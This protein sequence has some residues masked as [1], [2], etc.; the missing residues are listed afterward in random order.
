MQQA[1]P[2]IIE[3]QQ[4]AK[5]RLFMKE[6]ENER[7]NEDR[8]APPNKDKLGTGLKAIACLAFLVLCLVL[9]LMSGRKWFVFLLLLL[10]C[11]ACEEWLLGKYSLNTLAGVPLSLVSLS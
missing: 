1:V 6:Q 7:I 4:M 11:Y 3:F 8:N 9:W 5:E 2:V 10:P